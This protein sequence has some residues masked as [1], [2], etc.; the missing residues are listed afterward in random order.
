MHMRDLDYP[1]SWGTTAQD[2]NSTYH[3]NYLE[4]M[5]TT[6]SSGN[7]SLNVIRKYLGLGKIKCQTY[8]SL[9]FQFVSV[10]IEI[11]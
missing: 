8:F 7:A 2:L 6:F 1:K 11:K 4:W 5:P 9:I 10:L 3:I